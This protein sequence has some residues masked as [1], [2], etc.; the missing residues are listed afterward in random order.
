MKDV[1]F[2]LA[3]LAGSAACVLIAWAF[4]ALLFCF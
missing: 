1:R 3:M 2:L 4:L